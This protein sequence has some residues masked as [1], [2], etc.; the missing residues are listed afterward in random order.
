MRSEFSV[1]ESVVAHAQSTGWLAR[2]MQ[3]RGRV[4]CPDHWFFG[5]G[6]VV[7]IEFKDP[8]GSVMGMQTEEHKALLRA[9]FK[10]HVVTSVEAGI[11][12]LDTTRM[13]CR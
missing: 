9:G 13:S 5:F 2:R 7:I 11:K 12:I 1:E 3:Y 10:I 4:G 8:L 6:K